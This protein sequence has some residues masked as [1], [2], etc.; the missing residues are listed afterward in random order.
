MV[1]G[2]FWQDTLFRM[3]NA[4]KRYNEIRRILFC[5]ANNPAHGFDTAL[6]WLATTYR[7]KLD[8]RSWAGLKAELLL[9]R[10]YRERFHLTPAGDF[11]DH[12]DFT[13]IVD[14]EHCRIDV[15][16]NF[17]FKAWGDYEPF[18]SEGM[19]YKIALFDNAHSNL[20]R[21]IDLGFPRCPVCETAFLFDVAI[22]GGE[23]F[24]ESGESQWTHGQSLVR[25]CAECGFLERGEII[26]SHWLFPVS[27][28]LKE[29]CDYL[30]GH[31]ED[32]NGED[33]A[34]GNRIKVMKHC[35]CNDVLSYLKRQ[36]VRFPFGVAE[37]EFKLDHRDNATWFLVNHLVHPF[38]AARLP[39]SIQLLEAP[40][41]D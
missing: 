21:F 29:Y 33:G 4:A 22:L 34:I 24:S 12:T 28:Y 10:D 5:A 20:Q 37:Y 17:D 40:Q 35:Y 27:E 14:G 36:F 8:A 2:L 30:V 15:T 31:N 11:G 1:A 3:A 18:V 38:L 39:T 25:V 19:H 16:T 6:E 41:Q 7:K 23:N 32:A 13:G 26:S 9:Y